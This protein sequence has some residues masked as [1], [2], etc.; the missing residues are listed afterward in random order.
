MT[1]SLRSYT[2]CESEERVN[3]GWFKIVLGTKNT[4]Q[5]SMCLKIYL[6]SDSSNILF[7][8]DVAPI[9]LKKLQTMY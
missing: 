5:R 7:T 2:T 6:P 1:K 8:A 3:I 9:P 4:F